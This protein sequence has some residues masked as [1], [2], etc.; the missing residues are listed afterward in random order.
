MV[1]LVAERVGGREDAVEDSLGL[2]VTLV[3]I[4]GSLDRRGLDP[5]TGVL[6]G[7]TLALGSTAGAEASDIG[8][9]GGS[10]V[11][12]FA[13]GRDADSGGVAMSGELAPDLTLLSKVGLPGTDKSVDTVDMCRG[14]CFLS[15]S[16]RISASILRSDS[17][18]RSR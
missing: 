18:C 17:S 7:G 8:G 15:L 2:V 16:C 10:L 12:S 5:G 6:M 3:S 9:D 11:S 4:E 1:E 13:G 14:A